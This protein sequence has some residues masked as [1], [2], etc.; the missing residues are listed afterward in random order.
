M[1]YKMANMSTNKKLYTRYRIL[2]LL[3][4]YENYDHIEKSLYGSVIL[5]DDS[6]Y[7]IQNLKFAQK[8]TAS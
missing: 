7:D 2:S 4:I 5:H 3:V 1:K 8:Q 6:I